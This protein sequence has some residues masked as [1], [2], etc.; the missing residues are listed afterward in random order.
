LSHAPAAINKEVGKPQRS[1]RK[2]VVAGSSLLVL[3]VAAYLVFKKLVFAIIDEAI[4]SGREK[5]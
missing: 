3:A 1:N 4:K 2:P 5:I